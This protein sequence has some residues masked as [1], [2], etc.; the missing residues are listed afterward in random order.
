MVKKKTVKKKT[1][2]TK[3]KAVSVKK[4]VKFKGKPRS[5]I[6]YLIRQYYQ[7]QN[8]RIAFGGQIRAL[9][10]AKMKL[11]PLQGY[12]DTLHKIEKDIS[13][14]LAESVKKEEIWIDYLKKVKGVGPIMGAGLINLI[15]I[16]K[17][18]HISSLWKFAGFDVVKGKAPRLTRGQKTTWNPLMKALCWKIGK[19]FLMSKSPYKRFYEE[20]KKYEKKKHKELTKMHR[21]NRA[22]RFMVK[23]FLSDLWLEWR[24]MKGLPISA[25]YVI[26]KLGH[27]FDEKETLLKIK[28]K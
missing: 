18:R 21:H 6:V 9:K 4:K 15:D 22:L 25:P 12:F 24:A 10:E 1:I 23:R 16:K 5:E 26:D 8:H 3:K 19:S 14:H 2:V 20:R 27:K 17:A 13:T 28:K 7:V 11:G